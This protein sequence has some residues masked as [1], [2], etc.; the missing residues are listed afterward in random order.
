MINPFQDKPPFNSLE[1]DI[2]GFITACTLFLANNRL[3]TFQG[4]MPIEHKTDSN[5]EIRLPPVFGSVREYLTLFENQIHIGN[6][7]KASQLTI[8]VVA[9]KNGREQN[10]YKATFH[11]SASNEPVASNITSLAI[12]KLSPVVTKKETE[13]ELEPQ[14]IIDTQLLKFEPH[15]I[16]KAKVI[17]T[18]TPDTSRNP[19]YPLKDVSYLDNNSY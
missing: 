3:Q 4:N 11:N 8:E 5:S 2:S 10:L 12:K 18:Y 9:D 17:V 13:R 6:W 19:P 1:Q 7:E 14:F 15:S 16:N